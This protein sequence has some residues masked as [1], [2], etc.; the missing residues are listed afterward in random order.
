MLLSCT[1]DCNEGCSAYY[2]QPY[3]AFWDL[4]THVI[5]NGMIHGLCEVR[6]SLSMQFVMIRCLI[7]RFSV[8]SIIIISEWILALRLGILVNKWCYVYDGLQY[9]GEVWHSRLCLALHGD[10]SSLR[11][12]DFEVWMKIMCGWRTIVT[13]AL[14]FHATYCCSVTIIRASNETSD[15]LFKRVKPCFGF[16]LWTKFVWCLYLLSMTTNIASSL[17]N[18]LAWITPSF[19]IGN[20]SWLYL[21]LQKQPIIIFAFSYFYNYSFWS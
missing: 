11:F 6:V 17:T 18:A 14:F 20:D 9:V 15:A 16:C 21:I 5:F 13:I 7:N 4:F 3:T 19:W 1:N 10:A 8:L 12:S 2:E